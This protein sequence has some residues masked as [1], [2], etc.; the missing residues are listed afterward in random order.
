MKKRKI[1]IRTAARNAAYRTLK[2][3]GLYQRPGSTELA[4]QLSQLGLIPHTIVGYY[5]NPATNYV[6]ACYVEGLLGE[7]D[8]RLVQ[9]AP[10]A[11]VGSD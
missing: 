5:A 11:G 7:S 10:S 2:Q 6:V 8:P 3:H 9:L 4:L 1:R